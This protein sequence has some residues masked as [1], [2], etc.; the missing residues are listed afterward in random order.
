MELSQDWN[1]GIMTALITADPDFRI[2]SVLVYSKQLLWPPKKANLSELPGVEHSYL[3]EYHIERLQA[4]AS[5]LEWMTAVEY[6]SHPDALITL[7]KD[8][9]TQISR[10]YP[11]GSDSAF[12]KVRLA[13]STEEKLEILSMPF[14]EFSPS[15]VLLFPMP[16]PPPG[17]PE[18]IHIKASREVYIDRRPTQPFLF[19]T[20]KSTYRT[21]WSLA[22][23]RLNIPCNLTFERVSFLATNPIGEVMDGGYDTVYF[24][25][26]DER[27]GEWGWVV[28]AK[29]CGGSL[30][31]T[32]R[33]AVRNAGVGEKIVRVESLREGEEVWLS[34]GSWGFR[35][36]FITLRERF[37]ESP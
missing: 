13:F 5:A 36:G 4:S 25:R 34:S 6:L 28:P 37:E 3:L 14:P 24:W 21:H 11:D 8:I 29:E 15:T 10:T 35:R 27:S 20:N 12:Y 22:S 33:W 17:S 2:T 32:R 1:M 26:F 18:T 31:V 30:G 7:T 19:T 16:L 9:E 23:E